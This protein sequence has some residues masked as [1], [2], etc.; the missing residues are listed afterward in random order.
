[1][2]RPFSYSDENFTVIG[3]ILFIHI[4]ITKETDPNNIIEI[5]QAIHDRMVNKSNL[6]YVTSNKD[7][8]DRTSSFDC[9]IKKSSNDGKYY[10]YSPYMNI[11]NAI[12]GFYMLAWYFL[13][14]I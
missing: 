8:T 6:L 2:S 14:D 5:P 11:S 7:D 4:K 10:L 12:I 9:G 3:N 13:K 1:M